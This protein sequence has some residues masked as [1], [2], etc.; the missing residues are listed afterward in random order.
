MNNFTKL[1][2]LISALSVFSVQATTVL[3][4]TQLQQAE[5][6]FAQ[7]KLP[8]AKIIFSEILSQN[9]S[10]AEALA[11]L[12]RISAKQNNFDD[13]EDYIKKALK[14]APKDAFIQN[15]SGKI[16][17]SIAQNASI[18][19]ALGY[20]KKCLKG[21]R[22]A[23]EIIPD[24]IEYQQ[25]LLS[26]Y[27]GAPSIAG[28]DEDLALEHAQAINKLDVKQGYIAIGEVYSAT[29]NKKLLAQHLSSTPA[30]IQNDPEILLNKG[31]IYQKQKKYFEALASFKQ[32]A[33]NSKVSEH[34]NESKDKEILT[35][36]FQALYQFGKT[37][38]VSAK[39]M[40][41][42]IAALTTF[43]EKAPKASQLASKEWAQ[44]RL[45]NLLG[46][47][48]EKA[49]ALNLYQLVVKN[50]EDK[51]LKKKAEKLL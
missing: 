31:F 8:Q 51:Q 18:F 44:Y 5:Q 17:G 35:V 30:E 11:Y 40:D 45:A 16:Y 49:K 21:F 14:F 36:K 7:E 42:G 27:L 19:S 39:Q 38:D 26:F 47:Q 1:L 37:S 6:L 22:T 41:E 34:S 12:A 20:A 29:K 13:A 25:A 2:P 32:A 50:T 15:L 33:A 23:V 3:A 24:N 4:D 46:K 43:I 10:S 48:G 28:G 9:K